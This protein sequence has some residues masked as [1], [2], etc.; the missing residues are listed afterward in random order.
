MEEGRKSK[1]RTESGAKSARQTEERDL[2][3]FVPAGQMRSENRRLRGESIAMIGG[4]NIERCREGSY[5]LTGTASLLA[6]NVFN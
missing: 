6:K 3:Q 5:N 4:T 1:S 2:E